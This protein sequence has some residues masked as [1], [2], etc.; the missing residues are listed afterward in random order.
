LTF[1]S[2]GGPFTFHTSLGGKSVEMSATGV[3]C[4]SC[5]IENV[6][7]TAQLRGRLV[8]TGLKLVTPEPGACVLAS[9]L[10]SAPVTGVVGGELGSP[11]K[12][13]VAISPTVGAYSAFWVFQIEGVGCSIRG[14][15]KWTGTIFGQFANPLNVGAKIQPIAFSRGI[16]EE[17]GSSAATRFG[18]NGAWLEGTADAMVSPTAAEAKEGW[19]AQLEVEVRE[20]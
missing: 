8:F 2:F 3:S 9:P 15:Y 1:G 6:G 19:P 10:T 5:V 17:L 18:A 4:E 7:M 20:E 14:S 11:N 16:Q 13:T 12:V